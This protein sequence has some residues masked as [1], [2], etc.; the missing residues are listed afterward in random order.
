MEIKGSQQYIYDAGTGGWT[1]ASTV[2]PFGG[3]AATL[4]SPSGGDPI[5]GT[6]QEAYDGDATI[7]LFAL[8]V[9][10][11][12]MGFPT[13]GLGTEM[14]PVAA[15]E[16]NT[17]LTDPTFN[18]LSVHSLI[19]GE[20]PS[21]SGVFNAAKVFPVSRLQ[22]DNTTGAPGANPALL[23]ASVLFAQTGGDNATILFDGSAAN[24]ATLDSAGTLSVS[25]VGEWA[26]NHTPAA[27]TQA[28]ITR[29]A[30]AAGVRH[31]C[32]S[33]TVSLIGLAAAAEAT[34]L[35]NLRDGA[36]GAGTILWSTRLL[37]TG[38]TGSET[39]VTLAGLNIVG[40]AA[41]AMTLEFA[42]AGGANTFESVAMTGFDAS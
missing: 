30:G 23:T 32:R 8:D 3:A 36:T 42:A 14:V 39:G 1:P 9:R 11:G 41:T 10:S 21:D 28:T 5:G 7:N 20:N 4:V 37:V 12:V 34:V 17:E 31:V 16:W 25:N 22:F 40:S 19:Y 33:I 27:N 29:A 38:T 35:V 26:I 24:L 6:F 18:G 15:F 2:A 13:S